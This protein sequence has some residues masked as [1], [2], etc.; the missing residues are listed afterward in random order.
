MEY[1]KEY[2]FDD[3]GQISSGSYNSSI[4]NQFLKE[5]YHVFMVGSDSDFYPILVSESR[6]ISKEYK[7]LFDIIHCYSNKKDVFRLIKEWHEKNTKS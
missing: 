7:E 1:G 2:Y 3:C 6:L 4:N 5:P